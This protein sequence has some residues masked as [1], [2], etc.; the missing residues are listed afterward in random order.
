MQRIRTLIQESILTQS[1]RKTKNRKKVFPFIT[2]LIIIRI[3]CDDLVST[4]TKDIRID[5][6]WKGEFRCQ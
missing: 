3:I 1:L 4:S 6:F 5:E 2:I